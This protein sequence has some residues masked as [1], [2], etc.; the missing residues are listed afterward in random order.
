MPVANHSS[1]VNLR[2]LKVSSN[3]VRM[4]RVNCD[5]S[6]VVVLCKNSDAHVF[7][8]EE[9]QADPAQPQQIIKLKGH[10]Q[11]IVWVDV[12]SKNPD[13]IVSA[14]YDSTIRIWDLKQNVN[15]SS[16][17]GS[18]VVTATACYQFNVKLK[19]ALFSPL[20]E[21]C[22]LVGTQVTPLYV[23]NRT[24]K[25]TDFPP[26]IVNR[27]NCDT[28]SGLET[29]RLSSL[30]VKSVCAPKAAGSVLDA[31]KA[32]LLK[33]PPANA[34][35]KSS[36]S[37]IPAQESTI[38][39]LAKRECRPQK[40]MECLQSMLESGDEESGKVTDF[41]LLHEKIFSDDLDQVRKFLAQEVRNYKASNMKSRGT[42]L[43]AV[44]GGC[45][46]ETLAG[47]I[48][49]GSV[50]E[51]MVGIAPMVS[52][53]FWKLCS[54]A[55]AMQLI[56]EGQPLRAVLYLLCLNKVD[57]ALDVLMKKHFYREAWVLAKLRRPKEDPIFG[58]LAK[59]WIRYLDI[60]GDYE[61]A[62]VV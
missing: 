35:T 49:N 52:H 18:V 10:T 57:E 4:F 31:S 12:S 59:E 14:G 41:G 27:K 29:H 11:P 40:V 34:T 2:P 19:Y 24:T 53:N 44:M 61:S 60:T 39:Y 6:K 20:D 50:T 8:M 7:S 45:V 28:H 43:V 58:E 23:F 38:F 62:A 3:Y 36:D 48:R 37:K 1:V 42:E 15:S 32:N 16:D 5:H 51:E 22:L 55:F 13:L 21:N 30:P 56:E 25:T 9:L 26:I 47:H 33:E 17:G 46:R 54:E